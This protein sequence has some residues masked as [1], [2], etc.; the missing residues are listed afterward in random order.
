MTKEIE[1][2]L[3][4]SSNWQEILGKIDNFPQLIAQEVA[5][6][7]ALEQKV[8]GI[9]QAQRTASSTLVQQIS[10]K[11]EPLIKMEKRFQDI[12]KGHQLSIAA[13]VEKIS[14][15]VCRKFD[16]SADRIKQSIQAIE[17]LPSLLQ[18]METQGNRLMKASQEAEERMN[19]IQ[20][21]WWAKFLVI[22]LAGMIGGLS[23]CLGTPAFERLVSV[24][25]D[26]IDAQTYRII[27]NKATPEEWNKIH[28]ILNR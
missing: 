22:I 3:P 6:L 19:S 4:T 16:S 18:E 11:L 28:M 26:K 9:C 27:Y 12:T 7:I 5:P 20:P 10:G 8:E 17:R 25:I 14:G 2:N 15:Q 21:K 23:V 24:S 1:K 13:L